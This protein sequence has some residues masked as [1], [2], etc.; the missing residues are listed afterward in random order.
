MSSEPRFIRLGQYPQDEF[1][2]PGSGI[3][4]RILSIE[5]YDSQV[6]INIRTSPPGDSDSY[7][8]VEQTIQSFGRY[9]NKSLTVVDDLG[10][11]WVNIGSSIGVGHLELFARAIFVAPPE[12][13]EPQASSLTITWYEKSAH[14][15]ISDGSWI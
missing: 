1:I 2:I 14:L 15:R 8:Q 3:H 12:I 9:D 11:Y 10:R 4:A 6:A 7:R 13:S 5:Q